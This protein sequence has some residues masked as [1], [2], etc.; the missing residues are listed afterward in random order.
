MV[1]GKGE[2]AEVIMVFETTPGVTPAEPDG[3]L[4]PIF[5]SEIQGKRS[6][7]ASKIIRGRREQA[8]PLLGNSDVGGPMAV[9]VDVR[10]IGNHLKAMHGAPVTTTVST[11]GTLTGATGVTATI[12][13]WTA[14]SD[15]KFKV[16][17][18]GSAATEVGPIDFSSGVT[19]MANV[20]SKIQAAI[21][22]IAT[23]GFTLAT[24]AW[25]ATNTCFIITSGTTGA[26]SAVSLFT[27][28]AAGTNIGVTGFMKCTTGALVAGVIKYQHVF[29]LGAD[30]P[31]LAIEQG[32]TD[33]LHYVLFNG[34][35]VNKAGYVFNATGSEMSA[36]L[37]WMGLKATESTTSVDASPTVANF[38]R[39]EDCQLA[40]LEGGSAIANV[41]EVSFDVS[42]G[43]SGAYCVG[44][45]GN[46]RSLAEGEVE[47]TGKIRVTF[48]DTALYL[49][50]KNGMESSIQIT[51]T[52]G[53][54]SLD[55]LLS[56]LMYEPA[57]QTIP[58]K[59]G[60]YVELPFRAFY[61][62]SAG[63]SGII[64]TLVND[65]ASY[66]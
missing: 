38:D 32:F 3:K 48:E 6:L 12:G 31:S 44:G 56:E 52:N 7:N 10:D 41:E 16:A 21:R 30:Q 27:A 23:G 61:D 34:C 50:A 22:A 5:S 28:P 2:N 54:H 20:A 49:K 63:N 18:D 42:L 25:D 40:I 29:K 43:L 9:P 1:W 37:E 39:F 36:K 57:S 64:W 11:A 33:V 24:V 51:A 60:L 19:T 8:K 46:R 17:I 55:V 62:N 14:V 45:A 4:I 58:N 65:V 13:T 59:E 35:K 66:A 26:L 53:N 47:L 15:G